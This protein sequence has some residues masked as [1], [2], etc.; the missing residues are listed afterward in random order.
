MWYVYLLQCSDNSY[1]TGVT[2]DVK[3]RLSEHNNSKRAAR[4]TRS[5]RPVKMLCY[6]R[7]SSRSEACKEEAKIKGMK[8]VD[9]PIYILSRGG[10]SGSFN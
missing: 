4:Y 9:K 6:F 5:R 7:V 2:T 10:T 8:R 3:R 1:Y